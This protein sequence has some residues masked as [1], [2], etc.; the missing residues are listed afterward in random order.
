MG[1]GDW[2]SGRYHNR[3]TPGKPEPVLRA[4]VFR[5]RDHAHHRGALA[6]IIATLMDIISGTEH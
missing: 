3:A 1:T 2:T 4:L 5:P 6:A